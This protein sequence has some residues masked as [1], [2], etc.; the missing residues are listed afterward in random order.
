[1]RLFFYPRYCMLKNWKDKT[2]V[3]IQLRRNHILKIIYRYFH[4]ELFII[5]TT[6]DC[7]THYQVAIIR[8]MTERN[9]NVTE[10]VKI[11]VAIRIGRQNAGLHNITEHVHAAKLGQ[12]HPLASG[13]DVSAGVN[14]LVDAIAPSLQILKIEVELIHGTVDILEDGTGRTGRPGAT[15]HQRIQLG[16]V[17]LRDRLAPIVKTLHPTQSVAQTFA[18]VSAKREKSDGM[19]I[20]TAGASEIL[21]GDI[22]KCSIYQQII[23]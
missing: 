21:S 4:I 3:S 23:N 2:I 7:V 15:G 1:M 14:G 10:I 11:P 19:R 6:Y 17:T 13:V 8:I 9:G 18:I 5:I 16:E 20:I 22:R 12:R